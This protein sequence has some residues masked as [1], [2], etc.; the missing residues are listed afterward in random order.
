MSPLLPAAPSPE[1]FC[2][3][4]VLGLAQIASLELAGPGGDLCLPRR[5][6]LFSIHPQG[7]EEELTAPAQWLVAL[8]APP[9]MGTWAMRG[10][11]NC[12]QHP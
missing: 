3:R 1:H 6:A 5:A 8:L 11:T 10:Q 4:G 9:W 12:C 7:F 2:S